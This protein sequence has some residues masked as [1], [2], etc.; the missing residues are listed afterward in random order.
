VATSTGLDSLAS[1]FQ[2]DGSF[3]SMG[4]TVMS[5]AERQRVGLDAVEL[6][7]S[8][9]V[10]L[11]RRLREFR[12]LVWWIKLVEAVAGALCGVLV[13]CLLLFCLDRLVETPR[14]MRLVI[15]LGAVAAAA[16]IPLAVHRWIW[17]HRGL[18]QVAR[19]IA[20]RF[21]SLGDQLLGIIE[22]VRG[23]SSAEI[24]RSRTLCE[25]AIDLF[26]TCHRVDHNREES[27][28]HHHRD[29]GASAG[30]DPYKNER[31]DCNLRHALKT[32]KYR[33][34]QALDEWVTNHQR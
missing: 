24:A 7:L 26:E 34:N 2:F 10:E 16:A 29:L 22:M 31:R 20:R 8:L 27:D 14:W 15:S 9:P 18:D 6:P 11:D 5:I 1:V 23:E 3:G 33:H 19:L 4:D 13:A 32:N 25:A 30:P 17:N 12:G 21:P 28:R